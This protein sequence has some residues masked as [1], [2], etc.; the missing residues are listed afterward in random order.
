MKLRGELDAE[1]VALF[2]RRID[3][4]NDEFGGLVSVLI[5]IKW[6]SLIY[7]DNKTFLEVHCFKTK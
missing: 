2:M 4:K 3:V 7:L 1:N 6:T 5:M